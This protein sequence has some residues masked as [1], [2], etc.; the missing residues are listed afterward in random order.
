MVGRGG[1]EPSTP[2]FSDRPSHNQQTRFQS[3]FTSIDAEL[4]GISQSDRIRRNTLFSDTELAPKLT[5][6]FQSYTDRSYRERRSFNRVRVIRSCE[7]G[8][9]LHVGGYTSPVS[10]L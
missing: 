8:I 9:M 2:G 4:S 3:G 7:S 5:P 10:T 6:D 1:I